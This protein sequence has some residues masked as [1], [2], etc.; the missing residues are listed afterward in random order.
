MA[1]APQP[2]TLIVVYKDEV[3]L[4]FLRKL[5]E[6]N[7]DS[8]G[9]V[10]GTRDRSIN[11]VGWAEKV[12][13]DRKK[14]GNTASKRLFLGNVKDA[15]AIE[16][17]IDVK[18]DR[19]GIKYGWAGK[20]IILV[21]DPLKLKARED[22]LAFLEELQSLPI[23]EKFKANLMGEPEDEEPPVAEADAPAVVEKIEEQ[24]APED[25]AKKEPAA[26]GWAGLFKSIKTGVTKVYET[27]AP[28]LEDAAKSAAD[29]TKDLLAD[30]KPI[31]QQ[32]LF[33]GIVRLYEDHLE[34]FMT[35]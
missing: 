23:P 6:T 32:Q 21:A 17:I 12:W 20:Q 34:E 19:F 4:N 14:D 28:V 8:A 24:V 3:L 29:F 11:I 27:V 35:S 22:Y 13:E 16:P 18:F 2:Q 26:K 10:K 31:E 9:S 33:Y 5:V 7:D 25:P 15:A 30:R 1:F